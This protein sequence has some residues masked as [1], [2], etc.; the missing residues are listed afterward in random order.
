MSDSSSSNGSILALNGLRYKMPQNLSTT[1]LRTHKK[2]YAQRQSYTDG[3]T[4]VFDLNVTGFIDPQE[5]YLK[6]GLLSN[7]A[8][9]GFGAVGSAANVIREIRI[10]SKNGTEIERLQHANQ[11]AVVYTNNMCDQ[12]VLLSHGQ[13]AGYSNDQ[14]GVTNSS[15]EW[16]IP[17]NWIS[18]FFRPHVKG[19]K[20]PPHLLSGARIEIVLESAERALFKS[21]T[22]PTSYTLDN[23]QIMFLEHTLNDNSLKVLTEESAN[24]GLEYTY[25]RVFTAVETS[26]NTTLTMQIKKA[27]SQASS[28]ITTV[29]DSTTQNSETADSFLSRTAATYFSSFQY[30]LGSNYFPHQLCSSAKEAYMISQSAFSAIAKNKGVSPAGYTNWSANGM[31]CVAVPLKSDADISSSGLAVNNSATIELTFNGD[32]SS[33]TYYVFMIYTALSKSHLNQVTVKN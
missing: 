32:N 28:V 31:F 22:G 16:V 11:F 8:A 18:G 23:P 14:A 1:L 29:H 10:Q 15:T 25:D 17:L 9:S 13:L 26:S 6:F 19:Q 3:D 27:V 24:N 4:I 30:R 21:G 2:Q 33:K 12:D 20:I 7:V 5:S